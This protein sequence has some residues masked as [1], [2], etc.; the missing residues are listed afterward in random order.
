MPSNR[1]DFFGNRIFQQFQRTVTSTKRIINVKPLPENG[2]PSNF[3]GAVGQFELDVILSKDA[4]KASE[5]FQARVKVSGT[6]NLVLFKLPQLTTPNTLEVYEPEHEEK[7]QV[8]LGPGMQGSVEDLY[9]I[10]PRYQGNYPIPAI[11][12]SYFN[13]K[14][15]KYKT[16]YSQEQIVNVFDGPVKGSSAEGDNQNLAADKQLVK[17][18]EESAFRFI[19]LQ[20]NLQPIEKSAF[21]LSSLFFILLLFPLFLLLIVLLLRK[22]VFNRTVDSETSRQIFARR[23]AKKYLSSRQAGNGK[24][25]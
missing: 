16:L 13:P 18:L 25:N 15:K 9:T 20:T 12:F 10:V 4:L 7:V 17:P 2:K 24:A 5:S 8:K 14:T 1:R 6:G 22:Y 3:N 23:L 11:A 19:K 21:W